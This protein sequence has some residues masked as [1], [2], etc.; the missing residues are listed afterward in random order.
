MAEEINLIVN[1]E[2]GGEGKKTVAD[3]RKELEDAKK[4]ADSL[5]T[6]LTDGLKTA[7]A[8]AGSLKSQLKAMMLELGT[9]DESSPRFKQLTKDAG[10]LKDRI[11][12]IS[13]K[14]NAL[15]SDTK[16]L[17]ALVG[18]GSAIA[19]G[20]QA[21]SGAA[22]LFG[23][24]NK[25]VE[26]SIKNII[27][28]QGILNGV[29]QVG[30][31]LTAKG[32]VQDGLAATA[33][34]LLTGTTV[35]QTTAQIALNGAMIANPIGIIIVAVAALTAGIIWLVKNME[36]AIVVLKAMF[37]LSS[38]IEQ[39]EI[40][41]AK[42]RA[43]RNQAETDAHR[44]RLKQI[45]AERDARIDAADK[46]ISALE[47][48]K[49]TLEANGKSSADITVKILEAEK[50]KT[51]AVLDA[52]REKLASW[53][54]YYTNLQIISGQSVEDFKASQKAQGR[55]LDLFQQK[56][57]ELIKQNEDS[58][59][60][61]ENNIT[62]FKREQSEE[63][64]AV[65]QK[66]FEEAEKLRP[67]E[68]ERLAKEA[69]AQLEF[70]AMIRQR[71]YDADALFNERIAEEKAAR[72]EAEFDALEASIDAENRLRDEQAALDEQR[73]K[74]KLD[75]AKTLAKTTID[76]ASTVFTLVNRFG[77]QDEESKLKRA[78]RQFE[79]NKALA[80]SEAT[81]STINGV[82]NALAEK[83]IL[84]APLSTIAKAINVAS[85]VAAGAENVAKITASQFN[86]GAASPS[87]GSGSSGGGDVSGAIGN[88]GNQEPQ[89]KAINAGSTFLNAEPQ[90]VYVVE[91]DITTK[92]NG[93]KAIVAEATF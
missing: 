7:G 82:M 47:L 87:T 9:L 19:G 60:R 44:E 64:Q 35:K 3:V 65:N 41:S 33:R 73:Q 42:E 78:K 20:F 13:Q 21:A 61:S 72:E 93:I 39:Q 28:V 91:S 69:E 58:V 76:L 51:L 26:E 43:K 6:G 15:S 16:K 88:L 59:Q 62:K 14:V 53:V 92:Q 54:T 38:E 10:E 12:D 66:A 50:E 36:L 67:A 86:S 74:A 80:I 30:Q 34:L 17:D 81:T 77:K 52:N 25:K 5:S 83:S 18:V 46:Q 68:I 2:G 1:V 48:E 55:D 31:F 23:S 84:P 4:A 57:D 8:S 75:A 71:G 45:T 24:D 56:A 32:I 85:I 40:T 22:A 49:E 27:A 29:Q 70:D 11:G 89:V 37:G 63:R 79:I 90:K